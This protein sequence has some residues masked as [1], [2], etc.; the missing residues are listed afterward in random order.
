MDYS[1]FY[2]KN[3]Y[4]RRK[5]QASPAKPTAPPW[6]TQRA[7]RFAPPPEPYV[8]PTEEKP[9]A[10]APVVVRLP[11]LSASLSAIPP[12]PSDP[13]RANET[14]A[15]TAPVQEPP[16]RAG[17][18]ESAAPPTPPQCDET[19][20]RP[21][22]RKKGIWVAA[23][24]VAALCVTLFAPLFGGKS[25]LAALRAKSDTESYWYV[26]EGGYAQRN[27]AEGRAQAVAMGGGA[28]YILNTDEGYFVVLAAYP[29]RAEGEAVAAKN[30][31]STLLERPIRPIL[32]KYGEKKGDIIPYLNQIRETLRVIYTATL[33]LA[34]NE[35]SVVE[36]SY[37]VQD[38][39][40]DLL[41]AKLNLMDS[42]ELNAIEKRDLSAYSDP[43]LGGIESLSPTLG[44]MLYLASLRYLYAAGAAAIT[45][46]I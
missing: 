37:T 26:A 10:Q 30:D 11:A 4:S 27:A 29:T 39:H 7:Q 32:E 42:S 35:I 40:A 16:C 2:L 23:L 45:E 24:L 44:T 3:F 28:G 22:K 8:A 15:E 9:T 38:G 13:P 17:G 25:L 14:D 1:P 20:K 18:D 46:F 5:R 34:K 19:P 12:L 21:K 31:A 36:A 33:S 41:K 43:L 6:D